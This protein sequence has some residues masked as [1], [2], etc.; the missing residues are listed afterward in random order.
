LIDTLET[1]GIER[2]L[3]SL[4]TGEDSVDILHH[5]RVARTGISIRRDDLLGE[6]SE[7]FS[8]PSR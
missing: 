5:S 4:I 3:M 2:L 8:L 7:G 6:R 1:G